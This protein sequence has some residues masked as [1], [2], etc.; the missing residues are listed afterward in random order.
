MFLA[1]TGK[2]RIAVALP[3]TIVDVKIGIAEWSVNEHPGWLKINLVLRGNR[4]RNYASI[5][6][7]ISNQPSNYPA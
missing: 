6:L 4:L 3:K 7:V 1:K 5:R 2:D